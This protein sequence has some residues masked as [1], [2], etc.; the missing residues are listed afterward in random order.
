MRSRI[1]VTG[2]AG[3]I[4]Q[5]LVEHLRRGGRDV[6]PV[7]RDMVARMADVDAV[8]HLAAR[9][10]VVADRAADPLEEFRRV[11]VV[12]TE[13]LADAAVRCGVRRFV[14]VSSIGVLG[15]DSGGACVHRRRSPAAPRA[16]CS[17]EMGGGA[18]PARACGRNG[19]R[20]RDRASA[21]GVRAGRQGKLPP[22][23]KAGEQWPAAAVRGARGTAQLRRRA[24]SLRPARGVRRSPGRRRA[25]A[26]GSGWRGCHVA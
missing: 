21:A 24:E 8:V 19:D 6:L 13:Q 7:T 16:L 15:N 2:A 1:L 26:A 3:F 18:A 25:C 14:F 17:V 12:A 23:S 22:A 10:H 9:A 11:N 20:G 5:A 4:G